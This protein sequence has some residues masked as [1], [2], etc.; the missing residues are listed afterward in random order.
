MTEQEGKFDVM[1]RSEG[2]M[3]IV[4][5]AEISEINSRIEESED[6]RECY[7]LVCEKIKTRESR[8]ES[9]PDDLRRLERV[10]VTE[11]HAESQGR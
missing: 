9:V 5:V 3:T 7:Q 11:C 4:D 10:L 1:G 2:E 8:G 6:F